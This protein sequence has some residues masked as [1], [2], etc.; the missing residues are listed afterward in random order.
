MSLL[1]I[2]TQNSRFHGRD[3]GAEYDQPEMALAVGVRG[4]VALIADEV[5]QGQT[6]AAVEIS[7][8]QADGTQLLRSVV[9]VSVSQL[10]IVPSSSKPLAG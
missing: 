7:I 1:F 6:S 8:E 9:A 2:H 5:N 4:A 3:D 10:M